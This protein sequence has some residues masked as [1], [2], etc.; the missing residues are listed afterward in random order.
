MNNNRNNKN[1]FKYAVI[2]L[3]F[4]CCISSLVMVLGRDSNDSVKVTISDRHGRNISTSTSEKTET[5]KEAEK[6]TASA[7]STV[8]GYRIN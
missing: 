6:I 3:I 4:A 7:T 8:E 2:A 5:K 1:F